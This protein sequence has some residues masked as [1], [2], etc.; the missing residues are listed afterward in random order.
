MLRTVGGAIG[1]AAEAGKILLEVKATRKGDFQL[2]IETN[3]KF[4]YETAHRYCTLASN[5]SR[6]TDL[7]VDMQGLTHAYRTIGLLPE[8]SESP[9]S[10]DLNTNPYYAF[11]HQTEKLKA[12]IPKIPPEDKP[13]LIEW[14]L[15]FLKELGHTV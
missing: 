13:R 12:W 9:S 8:R 2:W 6:V 5:L 10:Q 4:S 15:S 14:C 11:W 3:C 1:L 7:P